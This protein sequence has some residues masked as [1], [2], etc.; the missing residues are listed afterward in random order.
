MGTL[1]AGLL[2][3]DA[4]LLVGRAGAL[5]STVRQDAARPV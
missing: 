3:A 4:V 2:V 1:T 5:F